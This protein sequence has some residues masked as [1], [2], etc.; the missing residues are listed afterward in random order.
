[1]KRVFSFVDAGLTTAGDQLGDL[2][3]PMEELADQI[4]GHLGWGGDRGGGREEW[5]LGC[6]ARRER[7]VRS[8]P[9]G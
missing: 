1:M 6:N 9:G 4:V 2:V 8:G 3:A 7:R 5:D